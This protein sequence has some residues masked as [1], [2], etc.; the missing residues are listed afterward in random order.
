MDQRKIRPE[1]FDMIYDLVIEGSFVDPINGESRGY[2][3]IEDGKIAYITEQQIQGRTKIVL[4]DSEIVFPGFIDTHV[5]FREPGWEHK[6]NIYSES[7]AAALGGVTTALEMPNTKEETISRDRVLKK[8]RIAAESSLID[9]E[10]YGGVSPGNLYTLGEM[11]EVIPG[12]KLFMCESTGNLTMENLDQ[13][14]EAFSQLQGLNKPVLVHAEDQLMNDA[15]MARYGK[16]FQKYGP[17]V[18]AMT[19]PPESEDK[20]IN[21]ALKLSR[22]YN[23]PIVV[24]H[25]STK[26]G[27]KAVIEDENAKAEASIHHSILNQEDLKRLGAFGKMNPPLRD[28]EDSD[29]VLD[30]VT[31]G[32][33]DLI[34]TDHAPHTIEEKKGDFMK[35]PSGV[36]SVEHYGRFA[37]LLLS[38][39][40]NPIDLARSSSYNAAQL[41]GFEDKG[42]IEEDFRADLVVVDSVRRNMVEPPY[43][44][45][46]GWSPFEGMEFTG[47]PTYTIKDGRIIAERGQLKE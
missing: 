5:H 38:R 22:K 6:G 44:S 41:F 9:L 40:M 4:S 47:E 28:Q 20:A 43:Q 15:A 26:E 17:L 31:N 42:R 45:K 34:G 37:A 39:G 36:P 46:C 1:G 3:G 29:Y 16:D 12:Y 23:V 13:I 30:S 33:V 11:L 25:I 8:K 21:D 32:D 19:R 18:H 35:A 7:R 10:F 14:E 24:C 2:I 27:M